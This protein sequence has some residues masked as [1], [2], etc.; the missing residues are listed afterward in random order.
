MHPSLSRV[1]LTWEI[2]SRVFINPLKWGN[3]GSRWVSLLTS[4]SKLHQRK[5]SQDVALKGT[6]LLITVLSLEIHSWPFGEFEALLTGR[7]GQHPE[8]LAYM[9]RRGDVK[10]VSPD[11]LKVCAPLLFVS[12]ANAAV[13]SCCALGARVGHTEGLW[14]AESYLV[15]CTSQYELPWPVEFGFSS[16]LR[17]H[18]CNP[19]TN[20]TLLFLLYVL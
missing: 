5:M 19:L 1:P 4:L 3:K 18:S 7:G 9:Y 15:L 17:E 20:S 2:A 13:S 8:P 16:C 14:G 11:C 12:Q 10:R 6:F